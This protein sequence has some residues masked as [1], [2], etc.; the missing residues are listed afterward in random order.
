MVCRVQYRGEH[1]NVAKTAL[2]TR[3]EL[4]RKLTR[5]LGGDFVVAPSPDHPELASGPDLLVGGR[6]RITAVFR[7][8]RY[9]SPRLLEA[10]VIATRLAFPAESCLAAMVEREV[11]PPRHLADQGFDVVLG[12][13]QTRDLIRLCTKG[14]S[15]DNNRFKQLQQIQRKHDIEYSTIL[16]I[17]ELRQRHKLR[18][19][20]ARKVIADLRNRESLVDG[21]LQEGLRSV[22]EDR[23][24]R[25]GPQRW[26]RATLRQTTVAALP[27]NPSGSKAFGLRTLWC[28]ALSDD[29]KL[30]RGVPYQLAFRPR[31]LLVE[32]WPTDRFDPCKPTRVAAF[33]SWLIAIATTAEDI[34]ALVD[35]SIE[36]VAKRI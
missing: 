1:A 20:S 2:L 14:V 33:S 31:I 12:D 19:K 30:D 4:S 35:R 5:E 3:F 25:E 36:M 8:G 15:D 18:P 21:L 11:E 27:I 34:E 7:V 28:E 10:R 16:Q 23:I 32:V 29:F 17:A 22:A 9:T 24:G 13:R 26:L 6:G